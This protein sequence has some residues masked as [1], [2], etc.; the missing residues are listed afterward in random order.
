[1]EDGL[2]DFIEV[3]T[4]SSDP[5][6]VDSDEDGFSDLEEVSSG[7]DPI[8]GSDYPGVVVSTFQASGYQIGV[9]G[10]GGQTITGVSSFSTGGGSFSESIVFTDDLVSMTGLLFSTQ[11]EK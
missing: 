6:L 2:S 5:L 11:V 10:E 8:S 9:F 1:M 7:N 3:N 4:H